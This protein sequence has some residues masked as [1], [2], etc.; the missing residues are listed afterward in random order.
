MCSKTLG[1]DTNKTECKVGQASKSA[2]RKILP[3]SRAFH[4]A[5]WHGGLN[6]RPAKSRG[7]EQ[8]W[9]LAAM[10]RPVPTHRWSEKSV[11]RCVSVTLNFASVRPIRVHAGKNKYPAAKPFGR[12]VFL[13][14]M[15]RRSLLSALFALP[16][17]AATSRLFAAPGTVADI[18]AMRTRWRDFL[19]A[20][21]VAPD[22]GEKIEW[23]DQR[24]RQQLSGLQYEVLRQEGT[25]RPSTSALNSEKRRGVFAC[26]GCDLPLFTSEMKYDSGTGWP[27]FFTSIPDALE[28]KR[29]FKMVWP[30][31]E[32]HCVRCGGHQGHIFTDGPPPGGERWCNNGVALQFAAT[33][34]QP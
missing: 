24:W 26:S 14:S 2:A 5:V 9:D 34:H 22:P 7:G 11:D 32:Y 33:K 6:K 12:A 27:S 8:A 25:E 17:V 19:P 16:V 28:T 23:D 29:D 4:N 10:F 31:T 20:D 21:F 15:K 13:T 3:A 1:L 30:R 18:E